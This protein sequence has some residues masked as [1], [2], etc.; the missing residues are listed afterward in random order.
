LAAGLPGFFCGGWGCG[1][2]EDFCPRPLAL[3]AG[4]VVVDDD[5]GEEDEEEPLVVGGDVPREGEVEVEPDV[6]LEPEGVLDV[7]V[8]DELGGALVVLVA[9]VVDTPGPLLDGVHDADWTVLPGGAPGGRP[10]CD[11]VVPGGT[12]TTN[13]CVPP[14]RSFTVTVQ[15]SA[16]A[17]ALPK[18]SAANSAL[19]TASTTISLGR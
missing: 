8:V 4:V 2:D 13:V 19:A 9:V 17:G 1:C 15:V 16:D 7:V 14:V 6:V 18:T 11:G 10:T 12:L 3:G 5:E